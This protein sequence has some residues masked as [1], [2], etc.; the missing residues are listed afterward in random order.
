MAKFRLDALALSVGLAAVGAPAL[1]QQPP[2]PAATAPASA[3]TAPQ[4]PVYDPWERTNRGLFSVHKGVDRAVLGPGARAYKAVTPPPVRRGVRNVFNNLGEPITFINDVLQGQP[5]RAGKTAARFVT[6]TTVGV[7]GVFDVASS[8][9]LPIHYEDFGQTLAVY[10][11]KPG[12]YVFIPVLGPSNLRD[13]GGRVLDTAANPVNYARFENSRKVK[14]GLYVLNGV[15]ARA[16]ADANLRELERTAT[17]EYAT[18]RSLHSQNR[19]AEIAN[20]RLGAADVQALPEFEAPP[21]PPETRPIPPRPR[22]ETPRR[23][24]R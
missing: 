3:S 10:G 2:V 12:P 1:A 22:P 17:D 18:I 5:T 8:A 9:G 21:P 13:V 7:L 20:G 15:D 6:N 23:R 14:T 16:A 11:V 4:S 19:N 24:R